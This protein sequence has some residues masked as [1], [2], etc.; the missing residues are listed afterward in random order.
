M[1]LSRQGASFDMHHDLFRSIRD[2]DLKSNFNLTFQG[3]ITRWGLLQVDLGS[4]LTTILRQEISW[5]IQH[6]FW[7]LST[8][9]SSRANEGFLKS[10]QS[11]RKIENFWFLDPGDLN[12]D[13]R[14]KLSECFLQCFSQ[15]TKRRFPFFS[16]LRS[17]RDRGGGAEINPPPRTLVFG[18]NQ[19]VCPS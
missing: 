12:F 19:R 7:L 5:A 1:D 2:L 8:Y 4:N 17:F 18:R 14:E 6:F 10:C 11:S 9:H 15:S 3:H 13:F 16:N